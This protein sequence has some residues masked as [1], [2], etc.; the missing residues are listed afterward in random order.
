MQIGKL[1][2]AYRKGK[3]HMSISIDEEKPFEKIQH[4]FM[5]KS[6]KKLGIKGMYFNTAKAIMTNL[7]L[8]LY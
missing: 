3:N 1:N 8:T 7:Q 2:T 6:L 4:T 5:I